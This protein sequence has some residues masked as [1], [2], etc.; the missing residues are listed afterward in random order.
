[1]G[2]ELTVESKV[3][4]GSTF[5]FAVPLAL[6]LQA[7]AAPVVP[8]VGRSLA[9]LV[10]DDDT[11]NREVASAMLRQLGHRP[12]L[13]A[14]GGAAIEAARSGVFDVVLMDLHM[15]GMNGIETIERIRALPMAQAPRFIMLTADVSEESRK[16]LAQTGLDAVLGK[17]LLRGA[18]RDALSAEAHGHIGCEGS[19]ELDPDQVVDDAFLARQRELLGAARLRRLTDLFRESADGLNA[20]LVS[21]LEQDDR[22]AIRHAAHQLGSAASALGLGRLFARAGMIEAQAA[23]AAHEA[24]AVAIVELAELSRD[25]LAALDLRLR[26]LQQGMREE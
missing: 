15:P 25:S 3:G 12:T 6:A 9:V 23:T 18:L 1:M 2:G 13:A 26:H 22:T 17:P 4:A 16:R 7:A 10:V 14:D 24:I 20:T 5:H 8:G 11:T 21:A 19:I